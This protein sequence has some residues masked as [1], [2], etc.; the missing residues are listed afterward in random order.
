MNSGQRWSC[1]CIKTV[2]PFLAQVVQHWASRLDLVAGAPQ[3]GRSRPP[4]DTSL[5]MSKVERRAL[6][7]QNERLHMSSPAYGGS[8]LPIHPA[9]M[10]FAFRERLQMSASP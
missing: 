10:L 8:L 2:M 9:S 6:R 1:K 7:K 4:R 3:K 5:R